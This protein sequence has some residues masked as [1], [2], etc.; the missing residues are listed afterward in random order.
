[1]NVRLGFA[2]AAVMMQPDVLLLDEVLAVGDIKFTVKCLNR[3][4]AMAQQS[5]VIFVSHSMRNISV[6][7]SRVL[8]MNHGQ[9][10]LATDDV[11]EGVS[12]Y[13]ALAGG[14]EVVAGDRTAR[15]VSFEMLVN[16]RP[17]D[18]QDGRVGL[19]DEV[20]LEMKLAI[21]PTVRDAVVTV[22]LDDES[23]NQVYCFPMTQFDKT[24]RRYS[25]GE[26]ACS[27]PLGRLELN[28]GRYTFLVIVRDLHR[29]SICLRH[30]GI[31]PFIA[32]SGVPLYG[33]I[34]RPIRG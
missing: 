7:C 29:N 2:V 25:S 15:I 11:Y 3:I 6:F 8:V 16:G 19:D 31:S 24:M 33:R 12:V 27:L 20:R 17:L 13:N 4:R 32:A 21:D 26:I 30:Q 22:Y 18:P 5:S 14:G 34:V 28:S 9:V 10:Q 23:F 1:M